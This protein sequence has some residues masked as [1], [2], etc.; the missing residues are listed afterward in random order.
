MRFRLI[1][2]FGLMAC[3]LPAEPVDEYHMKAAA[4]FNLAKFVEW[5]E[6]ASGATAAP[7]ELCI[8]GETAILELLEHAVT[9]N[10]ID[11]RKL[12][13]EPVSDPRRAGNCRMLF[14]SSSARKRWRSFTADAGIGVL[15]IGESDGFASEGGVVNLRIEGGKLRIEINLEAAGN[16]KLRISSRLLGLA[17]IVK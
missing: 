11:G 2:A 13:I 14:V 16:Q 6:A 7:L 15:T 12:V 9:G 17:Q 5:P 4:I 1:L 3:R 10:T 8:L